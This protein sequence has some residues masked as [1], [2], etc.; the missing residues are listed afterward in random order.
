MEGGGARGEAGAAEEALQ[1]SEEEK[2]AEFVDYGRRDREDDE[3]GEGADVGD[4]AANR[5]DFREGG[6]EKRA[7]TIAQDVERETEGGFERF[8]AEMGHD[9]LFAGG[10][11]GRACID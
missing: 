1:E 4:V 10:V 9:A 11:N 2:T 3:E 8:D 7:N 6:E 5:G